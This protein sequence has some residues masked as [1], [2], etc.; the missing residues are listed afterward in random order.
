VS[1][2]SKRASSDVIRQASV[3]QFLERAD[4]A[5]YDDLVPAALCIA[6]LAYPRLDS[7]PYLAEFDRMGQAASTRI[8]G[9]P[10]GARARVDALSHYLYDEERFAGNRGQYEDPRNS[11]LNE[12]LDRRTGIPITLGLVYMEVARRAG[13]AVDGVNFPGHFLLR[14]GSGRDALILDPFNA[15][16]VLSE[17]DCRNL[18][19]RHV[20]SDAVFERRLLGP[21]SKRQILTRMLGNL[22][23]TY[24]RLRSFPQA[25]DVLEL[26]VALDPSDLGELRDRGLVAYHLDDVP[27]ALRDLEAYLRL[28]THQ[29]AD[30]ETRKEFAQLWEHVKTLRRRLAGMN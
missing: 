15:G 14:H 30:P 5:G 22:K 25:R 16:T 9:A 26:L 21:A 6:E 28:A 2:A 23:R 11:F 10:A 1:E 20:G 4:S 7:R 19:H 8:P 24:V 29:D 17:A 27:G 18:L 13:I 3:R 12:V